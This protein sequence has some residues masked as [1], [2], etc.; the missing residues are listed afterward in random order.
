M[1]PQSKPALVEWLR[2][3]RLKLEHN[4][5]LS[6][7]DSKRR[8]LDRLADVESELAL[9][10]SLAPATVG[11][12]DIPKCAALM[13]PLSFAELQAL[14]EATERVSPHELD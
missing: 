2:L 8:I 13:P 5:G 9:T 4:G 3:A 1:F 11:I 6:R 7:T 12:A 10:L 14:E